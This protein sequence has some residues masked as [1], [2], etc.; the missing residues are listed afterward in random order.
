MF[1]FFKKRYTKYVPIIIYEFQGNK[2]LLQGRKNL[3][4]GWLDFSTISL[5]TRATLN[6]DMPQNVFDAKEQFEKLLAQND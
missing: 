2:Y 3:I 4:T 1:S 5:Q 6:R